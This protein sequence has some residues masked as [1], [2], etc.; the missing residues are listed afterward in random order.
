MLRAI[1]FLSLVLS[2]VSGAHA[3]EPCALV[4]GYFAALADKNYDKAIQLTSGAAQTRT[5]NW[6]GSLEQEAAQ[7]HAD[8]QLRVQRLDVRPSDGQRVSVTFHIDVVGK[9][10]CF[11][12]VAR[13]LAGVAQFT[14]ANN[15]ESI[16]QIDGHIE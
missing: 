15:G 9:K 14:V 13:T 11:S 7:H 16:E 8:V 3:Q 1:S 4:R 2:L 10:L 5:R 6:V 12:K